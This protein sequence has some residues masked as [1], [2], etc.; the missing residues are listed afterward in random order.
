MLSYLQKKV[1]LLPILTLS[2][3]S[4]Y[5]SAGVAD[6]AK[7]EARIA[8]CTT[9]MIAVAYREHIAEIRKRADPETVARVSRELVPQLLLAK[10]YEKTDD[11]WVVL[12][13][14]ANDNCGQCVRYL[15]GGLKLIFGEASVRAVSSSAPNLDKPY[16]GGHSYFVITSTEGELIVDYS[17]MQWFI[18]YKDGATAHQKIMGNPSAYYLPNEIRTELPLVFVGSRDQ[19]RSTLRHHKDRLID[20]WNSRTHSFDETFDLLYSE[21]K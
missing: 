16:G 6:R 10:G 1:A 18:R 20:T 15:E 17:W 2:L 21:P 14:S 5:T 13:I 9:E 8:A 19:L 12:S 3:C 7:E 11:P 4:Q